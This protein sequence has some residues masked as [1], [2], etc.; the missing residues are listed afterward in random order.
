MC[1]KLMFT[2]FG[3]EY[4][5]LWV[6]TNKEDAAVLLSY[7][8]LLT[9]GDI[10]H[11]TDG[12][13]VVVLE[14]VREDTILKCFQPTVGEH[15]EDKVKSL[16]VSYNLVKHPTKGEAV[17]FE[18]LI[19]VEGP[20]MLR[21]LIDGKRWQEAA[22]LLD[23]LRAISVDVSEFAGDLAAIHAGCQEEEEEEANSIGAKL[24]AFLEKAEGGIN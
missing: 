20:G 11:L 6:A 22:K 13:E 15:Y 9:E 10:I 7:R 19:R 14:N 24:R 12:S 1:D 2:C 21:Q 23:D 16:A 8:L 18:D 3:R 5:K 4:E 17:D